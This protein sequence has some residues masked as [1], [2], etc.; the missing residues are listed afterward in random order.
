MRMFQRHQITHCD[1]V[2]QS[3]CPLCQIIWSSSK[4]R[5]NQLH[6]WTM[7]TWSWNAELRL[8]IAC[9]TTIRCM[10]KES[11]RFNIAFGFEC[12]VR[13]APPFWE[14]HLLY[15]YLCQIPAHLLKVSVP[16]TKLVRYAAFSSGHAHLSA[17]W[18]Y[19]QLYLMYILYMCFYASVYAY[20]SKGK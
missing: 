5:Q 13:P 10:K 1:L 11:S 4:S 12:V 15:M 19:K 3:F 20:D 14:P 9:A 17:A 8:H 6:W 16:S 18:P 2:G 7:L